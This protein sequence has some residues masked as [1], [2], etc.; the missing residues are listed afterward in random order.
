MAATAPPAGLAERHLFLFGLGHVAGRLV[1][2]ARRAGI[3]LSG[4][5]RSPGAAARWRAQGV[6]AH[7]FD[8]CTALPAAALAGVTDVLVSIPP[9]PDPAAATA[10][11]VLGPHAGRLAPLRWVGV[12]S[13]TAVHGD[14]G[15]AWIDETAACRPATA[16]ARARLRAEADWRAFGRM[17]GTPVEVM[18]L[19]GHYG[20]GRSVIDALRVGRARRIVKPGH[21]FN[22]IHADDIAACV[23]AAM[24]RPDVAGRLLNL[25]DDAPEA[26]EVLVVHAAALL[27]VAP[28][29]AIAWDDPSL[30]AVV[31][32]FHA[33]NRRIRNARMKAALGVT[34]RH[35]TWREGLA[36]IVAETAAAP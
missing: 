9:D 14:H 30:P 32:A 2:M 19:P 10:C 18:R 28:P 26:A 6:L 13:S 25:T 22:R 34:L 1:P 7:V 33:E 21:V 8:G 16:D 4:S 24:A 35:P 11:R 36:A 17:T 3:R 15:G 27:G 20:P 29:P 23:L 31:R 12:L 5:C